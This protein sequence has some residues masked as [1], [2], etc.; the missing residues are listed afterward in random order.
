MSVV[1]S[2]RLCMLAFSAALV[3]PV[4]AQVADATIQRCVME[5]EAAVR[6]G[7]S[8]GL[9]LEGEFRFSLDR[10]GMLQGHFA[11]RGG[12]SLPV[13]GQAIGRLLGLSFD[14]GGGQYLWGTGAGSQPIAGPECGAAIG[15]TFA[16]PLDGDIGDWKP[17]GR[18]KPGTLY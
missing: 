13:T 18:P 5:F 12:R 11:L 14:M 1:K 6:Q 4:S 8:A 3:A 15:G 2:L 17:K 10:A 9:V 16:G 7:P